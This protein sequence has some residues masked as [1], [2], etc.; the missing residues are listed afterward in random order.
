MEVGLYT[1]DF[2]TRF[3]TVK[4]SLITAVF[5]SLM[6][7]CA[8]AATLTWTGSANGNWD[9]ASLNWTNSV[10][11]SLAFTA[12]DDVI[13]N[14]NA[15][16]TITI[17][18]NMSPNSTT[19]N[20]ASGTY[21]FNGGPIDSGSFTKSGAGILY[22]SAANTFAGVVTLSGG[23]LRFTSAGNNAIGTGPFIIQD[24]TTIDIAGNNIQTL[25]NSQY[26]MN[27]GFSVT[28]S[29]GNTL[30]FS[31]GSVTMGT[32]LAITVTGLTFNINNSSQVISD[33]GGGYGITKLGTGT[34]VMREANTFTGKTIASNGTLQVSSGISNAGVAGNL[35][36]P[37][38]ANA[39]IDL[40]PG[41]TMYFSGTQGT[42]SSDRVFN[43]AGA[44]G[45]TTISENN[46]DTYI[47]MPGI[48]ATGTGAKTLALSISGDR[49]GIT[50]SGAIP[51]VSDGSQLSLQLTI[52]GNDQSAG[53]GRGINLNGVNTFTGPITLNA[54]IGRLTIGGSGQLGGGYY[55]NNIMLSGGGFYYASSANQVLSGTIFN[56]GTFAVTGAGTLT[57]SGAVILGAGAT[58]TQNSSLVLSGGNIVSYGTV[59]LSGVNTNSCNMTIYSGV[60]SLA[61]TNAKPVA[62][63][64]TVANGAI[65]GLAVGGAGYFGSTD[66]TSLF[67]G[68]LTNVSMAAGSY[69]GIDTTAGNFTY[70]SS[71]PSTTLGLNKLGANILTLSGVNAYSGPTVI[72]AGTL[73]LGNISAIPSGGAVTV[74]GGIYDL[75]GFAPVVNGPITMTSGSITNG[76]LQGTSYTF[77]GGTSYSVLAGTGGLTN[78]SGTT[79]LAGSSANTFSGGVAVNGGT[80][81]LDFE[82][83]GTP[84]DLINNGNVL[85]LGGGTLSLK[86]KS[87][88]SSLQTFASTLLISNTASTVTL[89]NNGFGSM[90]VS[91]GDITRQVNST[92]NFNNV[93]DASAKIAT[94]TLT[95][96]GTG[97]FAPWLTV[98]TTT[99]LQYGT[100]NASQQIVSYSGA[101]A[102]T[103]ADLSN[104]TN[105]N[106]NYSFAASPTQTGQITGNTLRY[107][108]AGD[109]LNNNGNNITLNGLMNAG[110]GALTVSGA[111]NM[112]IGANKELVILLNNQSATISCPIVNNAGGASSVTISSQSGGLMLNAVSTYTGGTAINGGTVGQANLVDGVFGTGPITLNGGATVTFSRQNIT[113]QFVINSGTFGGGNSFSDYNYGPI[114]LNGLLTIDTGG[115]GQRYLYGV[116]SG[117]GGII[118]TGA[119][120]YDRGVFL[121]GNNTYSGGTTNNGGSIRLYNTNALGTGSLT[122]NGGLLAAGAD[123]SGGTGVTNSIVLLKDSTINLSSNMLLSGVISG[124]GGVTVAGGTKKLILSGS[125]T[126]CGITTISSG[127]LV[128]S[129]S[130]ALQN[131]TLYYNNMSANTNISFAAGITNFTLGGL[132]GSNNLA[133]TNQSGLAINLT[134]GN[135]LGINSTYDGVLSGASSLQKAG[136]GT[137]TLTGTNAFT[138]SIMVSNGTLSVSKAQAF[139]GNAIY[140]SSTA[141]LNLNFT[142]TTTNYMLTVN[143]IA[144]PTGIYGSNNI[145]QITGPGKVFTLWPPLGGLVIKIR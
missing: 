35:G 79:T 131:S 42:Y 45:T 27:G 38:G 51:D 44:G 66:I 49:P 118:K 58:F 125:N 135:N 141:T 5:F 43:L 59:N 128:L 2:K 55:A 95:G 29:G 1:S 60:L 65:L 40:Y 46:N 129:N 123:L 73:L 32:N 130:L 99:A 105:P 145:S 83:M 28:S 11:T 84:T 7:S 26:N 134:V 37:T 89:T 31:T 75:G 3:L 87:N 23:T 4:R 19:V 121:F 101:T 91:M 110:S 127:I 74:A 34:L 93:P 20:A 70:S 143:G 12:G 30:N 53:A 98:G 140:L 69:V 68:T 82:N 133:L 9:A 86:E 33:G 13:F 137:F 15:G 117:A 62:G 78:S 8:S 119:E 67:A 85:K 144:R 6:I 76:T 142:G 104:V 25:N 72:T 136:Y 126:F 48:T 61:S 106:V 111:G 64:I 102:G 97:I 22:L 107:S 109:T 132:T 10:G 56:N 36:A 18:A 80:L 114:T 81:T 122:M 124:C 139:N 138:G 63:V 24:G 41:A 108:G 16:G 96:D 71:I 94:T 52:T 47:T 39:I 50:V 21:T 116:I 113:N 54:V 17:S 90:T 57:L 77:S 14:N 103:P 115:S 92:L 112:V 120:M 100:T 88:T